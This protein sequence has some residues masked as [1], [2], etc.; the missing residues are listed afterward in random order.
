MKDIYRDSGLWQYLTPEQRVLAEDGAFLRKDSAVHRN[1]EPTDYSYM[2]FPYAKMY[3]GFLK[4]LFFDL[5]ILST[6]DFYS[7][8]FRIGKGLSPN[9][10]HRLGP[11]SIYAEF[12]KRYG[13]EMADRLWDT[14][15]D[16]RNL[17][18][19][20]FPHNYRAL[21]REHATILIDKLISTMELAVEKTHVRLDGHKS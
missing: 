18:F 15:K 11:R 3:E 10:A 19:H 6:R 20:Y 14:W 9:L 8:H 1:E 12:S 16:A 17:V 2:V 5:N 4:Q 7:D 13:E 21:S